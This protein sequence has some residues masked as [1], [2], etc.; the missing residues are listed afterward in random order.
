VSRPAYTGTW[1]GAA[2]DYYNDD[3]AGHALVRVEPD[4]DGGV[5]ISYWRDARTGGQPDGDG[6]FESAD[7]IEG[8][9]AGIDGEDPLLLAALD[10][11]MLWSGGA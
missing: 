7:F 9:V 6:W 8:E 1:D 3:G 2:L 4:G 10:A 5:L 11:F